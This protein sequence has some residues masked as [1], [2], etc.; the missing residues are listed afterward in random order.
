MR[1]AGGAGDSSPWLKNR[2]PDPGERGGAVQV[3]GQVPLPRQARVGAHVPQRHEANIRVFSRVP[4]L[5]Q[6]DSG[7]ADEGGC[8]DTPRPHTTLI[9]AVPPRAPIRAELV[10]GI[11]RYRCE[12][13]SGK[14]NRRD[15]RSASR[16]P[17]GR[18]DEAKLLPLG[19][20]DS[21][22]TANRRGRPAPHEIDDGEW[23]ARARRNPDVVALLPH[24]EA[25]HDET[26]VAGA[27]HPSPS[28]VSRDVA[29]LRQASQPAGSDHP[30]QQPQ[31]PVD[32][33]TPKPCRL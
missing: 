14:G 18:V 7:V 8:A 10:L 33:Q 6:C 28:S 17:D 5:R 9:D 16:H 22:L 21:Q 25:F 19:H 30:L 13:L 15:R 20:F 29:A 27:R 32:V 24:V 4:G 31:A 1:R 3:E 11:G 26:D 23:C 2:T 12:Q